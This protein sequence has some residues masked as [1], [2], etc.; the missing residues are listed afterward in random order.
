LEQFD[1]G[2]QQSLSPD[3][4]P[5]NRQLVTAAQSVADRPKHG[6]DHP[7]DGDLPTLELLDQAGDPEV[8]DLQGNQGRAHHEG[9]ENLAQTTNHCGGQQV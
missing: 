5:S 8:A 7:A 2:I 6:A 3:G 4:Q 1:I 9:A